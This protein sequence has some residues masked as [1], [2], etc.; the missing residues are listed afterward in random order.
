MTMTTT[1][2]ATLQIRPAT[3]RDMDDIA[4]FIRSTADWYRPFVDD[5]DMAEH[6]VPEAWKERN[7]RLRDFYLGELDADNASDKESV[8]TVSLQYFGDYAY[9]GYVY[10]DVNHV[11]KGFGRQLLNFATRTAR[12]N[13]MKGVYLIAHPKATWA[14]K[15]YLKY[16]FRCIET[17]REKI[18][19]WNDGALKNYYEE[20]FHLFIYSFDEDAGR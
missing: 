17:A 4:D 19:A 7:Y 15:A 6:D 8:G 2:Q 18:L 10:L 20:G 9:L 13:S 14:I 11:G 1:A 5:E 16:G 3:R 12:K